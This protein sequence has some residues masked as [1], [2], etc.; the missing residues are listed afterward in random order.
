MY[1]CS[2]DVG[3]KLKHFRFH[4]YSEI[5]SLQKNNF[6]YFVTVLLTSC[7]TVLLCNSTVDS[8]SRSGSHERPHSVFS[9]HLQSVPAV[10]PDV[11][12][13]HLRVRGGGNPPLW[14]RL[15]RGGFQYFRN[16]GFYKEKTNFRQVITKGPRSP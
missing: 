9:P 12:S 14:R 10:R 5:V 7:V 11:T 6:C 15:S 2:T 1:V 8:R 4:F 3:L 16:R 13:S